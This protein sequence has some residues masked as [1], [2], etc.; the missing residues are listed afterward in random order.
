MLLDPLIMHNLE[1]FYVT[2]VVGRKSFA[3]KQHS[4]GAEFIIRWLASEIIKSSQKL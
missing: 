2:G 4:F 3:L 1:Q